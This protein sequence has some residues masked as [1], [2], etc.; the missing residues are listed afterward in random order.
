[1][2][3]TTSTPSK[4]RIMLATL[5]GALFLLAA[6]IDGL[7]ALFLHP[8]GSS[9]HPAAG[10]GAVVPMFAAVGILWLAVARRWK[11]REELSRTLDS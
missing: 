1:M 7:G 9:Q 5:A 4:T 10:Q 3:P 8:A 11:R 2:P 6:L